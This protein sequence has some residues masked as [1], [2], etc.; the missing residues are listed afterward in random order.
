MGAVVGTDNGGH[1]VPARKA[2]FYDDEVAATKSFGMKLWRL[3]LYTFATIGLL[4]VV[5]LILL[6]A[7]L[8]AIAT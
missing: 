3:V 7:G 6:V 1:D 5:G 8:W 2:R 4:T